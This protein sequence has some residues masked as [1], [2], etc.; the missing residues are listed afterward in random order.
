MK[1]MLLPDAHLTIKALLAHEF[2]PIAATFSPKFS[3]PEKYLS[4][5]E[6][7]SFIV[8]LSEGPPL[9]PDCV[10]DQLVTFRMKQAFPGGVSAQSVQSPYNPS[11]KYPMWVIDLW[12][13]IKRVR[14]IQTRWGTALANLHRHLQ[15]PDGNTNHAL[16]LLQDTE[17]ALSNLPWTG[18]IPGFHSKVNRA[19]LSTFITNEWLSDDHE[20]LMLELLSRCTKEDDGVY[21]RSVFFSTPR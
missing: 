18:D 20:S 9:P 15:H 4:S 2:P 8:S 16:R 7:K 19:C 14:A 11:A 10:V 6:P 5:Q 1:A 13:E 17:R 21:I 3:R 12:L